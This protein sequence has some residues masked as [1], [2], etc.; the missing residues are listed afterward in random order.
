MDV[1]VREF[2]WDDYPRVAELWRAAFGRDRTDEADRRWF[3]RNPGLFLVAER[4][5]RLIGTAFG[6]EDGR[7]G[8]VSRVAVLPEERRRGVATALLA[9]LERR[10]FALGLGTIHLRVDAESHDA[11][12]L[13]ESLGWTKDA[14]RIIGMRRLRGD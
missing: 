2:T 14:P 6:S 3:E 5:G 13:Y 11:I 8:T 7:R 9:D 1:V 10:L 12:A 4:G